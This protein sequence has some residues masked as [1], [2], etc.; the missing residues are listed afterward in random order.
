MSVGQNQILNIQTGREQRPRMAMQQSLIGYAI[1][2][3]HWSSKVEQLPV[4]CYY[5][6]APWRLEEGQEGATDHNVGRWPA[7]RKTLW[8]SS[9]IVLHAQALGV[10]ALSGE[11]SSAF[12]KSNEEAKSLLLPMSVI[13]REMSQG[14]SS[15]RSGG[16]LRLG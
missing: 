4:P 6:M 3:M 7:E 10:G 12:R 2:T 14:R 15:L 16:A 9:A 8:L 13:E 5:A 11:V 1:G